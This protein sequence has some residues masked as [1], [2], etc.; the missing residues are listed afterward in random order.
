MYVKPLPSP[1]G[2]NP[3][4]Y[5]DRMPVFKVFNG[6][7]WRL[8]F[9]LSNPVTRLPATPDNTVV[10]I[11]L[12]ENRFTKPLWEGSWFDGILPSRTVRGLVHVTFPEEIS[13]ALRRGVYAFSVLVADDLGTVKETQAKGHLQVEY[14][15]TSEVHNIPYR[16]DSEG[17]E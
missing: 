10:R 13:G 16:S 15:P 11:V 17:S 2:V 7:T 12:S 14:E 3:L 9:T 1:P 4:V 5:D 6:D 8:D